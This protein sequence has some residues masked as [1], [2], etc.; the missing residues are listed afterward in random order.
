ML[1]SEGQCRANFHER[2]LLLD[3]LNRTLGSAACSSHPDYGA[4]GWMLQFQPHLRMARPYKFKPLFSDIQSGDAH[5]GTCCHI[6]SLGPTETA[7]Q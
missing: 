3:L 2:Q 7:W 4:Y 1:S 5:T 6:R